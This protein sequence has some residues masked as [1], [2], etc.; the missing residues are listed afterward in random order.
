M[1]RA[2]KLHPQSAR[3]SRD[4]AGAVYLQAEVRGARPE[5]LVGGCWPFWSQDL[6]LSI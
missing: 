2:A 4:A 6:S 5:A 1:L 3:R